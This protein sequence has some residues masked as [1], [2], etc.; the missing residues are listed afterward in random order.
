[1]L[2]L[3]WRPPAMETTRLL[4]RPLVVEDAAD[5]FLC[6][7]NPNM[8]RFTLWDAHETIADTLS[9]IE[10]YA[11]SRYMNREPDPIGIVLKDDPTHSVI[12]SVGCN[13]V[14]KKDGVMELGYS[15]AE[16]YWGR[17]L[18]VEAA[19]ALLEFAF[20]EYQVERIQARVIEGNFASVAVVE[21]LGM[22][23]EGTH[24]SL[25]DLRSHRVDV[26]YYAMLRGD[27]TDAIG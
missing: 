15:L 12:G 3:D 4:L 8:T 21:K 6:C 7:S 14:S 2:N 16:P 11:I 19:R 24:R 25:V 1:M 26:G 22:K 18:I 10:N 5:L 9:F 27:R 17:G 23:F 20:S 13:W